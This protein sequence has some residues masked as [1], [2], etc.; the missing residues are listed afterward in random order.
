M[1][2]KLFRDQDV[3]SANQS[4]RI[5]SN[6]VAAGAINSTGVL[7]EIFWELIG[8]TANLLRL[9]KSDYN[10]LLVKVCYY[11]LRIAKLPT[12]SSLSANLFL[13]SSHFQVCF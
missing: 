1:T 10:D 7:D 8:F 12:Y 9:K 5:L 13:L 4:L 3:L 2:T 11:L 6:L